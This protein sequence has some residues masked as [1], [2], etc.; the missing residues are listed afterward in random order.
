MSCLDPA[1][2]CSATVSSTRGRLEYLQH[3][4]NRCYGLATLRG[5]AADLLLIQN[6]VSALRSIMWRSSLYKPFLLLRHL[7][8]RHITGIATKR[9]D[10][11]RMLGPCDHLR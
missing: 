4:A 6:L 3:C 8:E 5:R 9:L 7:N 11:P 10:T 2:A 1:R